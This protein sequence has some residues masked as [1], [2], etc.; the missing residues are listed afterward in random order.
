M[1]ITQVPDEAQQAELEEACITGVYSMVAMH[2][3][4]LEEPSYATVVLGQE[5]SA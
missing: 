5:P 3:E 1:G 2:S 4:L